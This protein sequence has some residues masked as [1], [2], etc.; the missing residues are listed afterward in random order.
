[1]LKSNTNTTMRALI[2]NQ[3]SQ[4]CRLSIETAST[5]TPTPTDP[6]API[7]GIGDTGGGIA[8]EISLPHCVTPFCL[9]GQSAGVE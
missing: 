9:S 2:K 4:A 5:P 6:P 8:R 1:M 3:L 7:P